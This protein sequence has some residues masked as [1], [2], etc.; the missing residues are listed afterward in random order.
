MTYERDRRSDGLWATYHTGMHASKDFNGSTNHLELQ[1]SSTE[2]KSGGTSVA[3]L[4][5]TL[6]IRKL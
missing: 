6:T 5:R 3:W 1:H 4:H 2:W